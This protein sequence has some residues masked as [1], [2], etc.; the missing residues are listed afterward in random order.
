MVRMKPF[1]T[2]NFAIRIENVPYEL[3]YLLRTEFFYGI[4]FY[5]FFIT[6]NSASESRTDRHRLVPVRARYTTSYCIYNGRPRA[7]NNTTRFDPET[8]RTREC[9]FSRNKTEYKYARTGKQRRTR[10]CRLNV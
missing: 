7:K 3:L 10:K 2:L 1:Y 8:V 5:I 9:L 4:F 6:G